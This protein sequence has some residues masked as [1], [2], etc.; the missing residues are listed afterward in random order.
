MIADHLSQRVVESLAFMEQRLAVSQNNF[1][2]NIFGC[3]FMQIRSEEKM[4]T[5]QVTS[6]MEFEDP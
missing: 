5:G 3:D 6:V 1:K 2:C 4:S